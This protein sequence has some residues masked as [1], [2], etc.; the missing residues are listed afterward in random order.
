[1]NRNAQ[2]SRQN[3][4]R[5]HRGRIP[6]WLPA[7]NYYVL[8]LA[9][10]LCTFFLLWGILHDGGEQTPWI[11]S[12]IVASLVLVCAVSLRE[13]I[14]R[15]ARN[16]FLAAERQ[17]SRSLNDVYLK[18]AARPPKDEKLSLEQNAQLL[19]AIKKKSDAAITLARFA[20]GHREVFEMCGEYLSL[21]EREFDNIGPGSPRLPAFQSARRSVAEFHKYHLLQWASIKSR[22][23]AL[24]ASSQRSPDE[25]LSAA[26]GAMDVLDS[27]LAFYPSEPALVESRE[28]LDEIVTEIKVSDTIEK[29]ERAENE[30]DVAL[31][32]HL[33]RDALFFLGGRRAAEPDRDEF[34]RK[35]DRGLERLARRDDNILDL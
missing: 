34:L 10:S 5:L 19:R 17:F 1:M 8:A 35:I 21:I 26:Q 24:E 31:A 6:F 7:A 11:T 12:G 22:A 28:L 30:G 20:E 33:Y 3:P 14:L 23:L 9:I 13:I 25:R 15:R 27:A 2:R 16:K 18:N 4:T 29:A 32:R